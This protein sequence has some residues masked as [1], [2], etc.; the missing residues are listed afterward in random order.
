MENKLTI[1]EI[2]KLKK[3]N[4]KKEKAVKGEKHILKK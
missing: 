1:E 4:I 3:L 2:K